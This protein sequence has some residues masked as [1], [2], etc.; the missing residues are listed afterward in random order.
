MDKFEQVKA[1]VNDHKTEILVA[2][3]VLAGV[4]IGAAGL[5]VFENRELYKMKRV[6]RKWNLEHDSKVKLIKELQ[7]EF[8]LGSTD[9]DI[10]EAIRLI[11]KVDRPWGV[12]S[13]QGIIPRETLNN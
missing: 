9:A 6:F 13:I 7:V 4:V 5:H 3:G 11:D 10:K 1:F 2:S 8:Q 12:S